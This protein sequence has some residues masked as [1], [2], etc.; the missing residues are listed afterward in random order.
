MRGSCCSQGLRCSILRLL[1]HVASSTIKHSRAGLCSHSCGT[2]VAGS[3]DASSCVLG[4]NNIAR[5]CA[6]SVCI[7]SA[8]KRSP[9]SSW[10]RC[11]LRCNSLP[12]PLA[13]A[14]SIGCCKII[15]CAR[16]SVGVIQRQMQALWARRQVG[17]IRRDIR[18]LSSPST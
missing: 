7:C 16:W 17:Q 18:L 5:W 14:T 8:S 11:K 15:T 10:L 9:T 3:S 4:Y 13:C 2:A 12:L 6:D 1:R